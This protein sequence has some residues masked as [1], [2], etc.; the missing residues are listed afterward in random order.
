VAE[1]LH[2]DCELTVAAIFYTDNISYPL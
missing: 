1:Y 2:S